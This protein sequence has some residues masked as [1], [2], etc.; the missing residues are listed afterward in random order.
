MNI[1]NNRNAVL[2]IVL[3]HWKE[4]ISH[5]SIIAQAHVSSGCAITLSWHWW[6]GCL[7]HLPDTRLLKLTFSLWLCHGNEL[8][9]RQREKNQGCVK[10]FLE[11]VQHL[12]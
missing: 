1:E 12:H 7:W 5:I 11:E 4:K 8:S 3:I 2:T 10:S 9:E 6:A